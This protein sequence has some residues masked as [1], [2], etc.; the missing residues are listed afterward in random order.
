M[1]RRLSVAISMACVT[2]AAIGCNKSASGE[3]K[4][5]EAKAADAKPADAKPP[6]AAPIPPPSNSDTLQ[7]TDLYHL[8]SVGDVQ[9]SP[10]A[11][12]VAYAGVNS[13]RPGRPYSQIWV[14]NVA[15]RESSRLGAAGETA[16]TP[17]WSPS[18][19]AIAYLGGDGERFG[20]M[21]ANVD[22]ASPRFI[23][24]VESTNHPLP[25]SG[26]QIAWAPDGKQIAF[27]SATPGPEQDANGDPMVVTR[28]LYKPTASEGFTRFN[29]NRRL[30]IF[31][32]DVASGAVRQLTTG[33]YFE[34]SLHWSPSGDRILFVSN[35]ESDPDRF[36]NYDVFTVA[37]S[38]GAIAQ[39]TQTKN[40]EYHPAWSPDG[41]EIAYLGTTRP[42]T[43]SETTME[44][45][46][47]WV[48]NADGSNRHELGRSVDNRQGAPRWSADG[49]VVYFTVQESGDT[50]LYRMPAA[51][52]A[53]ERVLAESG[54]V[55]SWSIATAHGSTMMAY[56]FATPQHPAELYLREGAGAAAQATQLNG[57]LLSHKRIGAVESLTFASFDG[58][59]IQAFLTQPIEHG[60]RAGTPLI[61]MIHGGPHGQQGPEFNSR[62]QLY[63]AR[64][65]ASLMVNYRG[66]TGYG[67]KLT[68]AIFNDQDGG[69]AKDVLAGVDAAL[70]RYPWL[71]GSRMGIEGGSYGGQLANWIITQTDRFKAAI[72]VAGISNLVTQNYLSYYHDYLAV[73]FGG[74][75]HQKGIIDRLWERSAI[76]YAN[77]VKT[78]T[79]FV[80]GEN[81]NDV[82]IA[83]AEQF[84]IALKD[85]GVETIMV[86]YPR[87]GHGIRETRHA[88]D[89]FERSVAWY[90][91]HFGR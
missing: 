28:Y 69:E 23:A 49:R 13:D 63:A 85:V 53:A 42:L 17:R 36:F 82:P 31:V 18:G 80:H 55:G 79:M 9:L 40:A 4:P 59:P 32:A 74:F 89:V 37:V 29:D 73:E 52:G 44:D 57:P 38:D 15:S 22:G 3:A 25:T 2:A 45:T 60:A 90:E 1:L 39:L 14:L 34:H 87:E 48:M 78:P 21:I 47:V 33:N 91:R 71:D 5:A 67:Q 27:V 26:E 12:R 7:V 10:D 75:P 56:A 50:H 86:R 62:A 66:S 8:R 19:Q 84:Y 65:W 30:H 54:S 6:A 58:M 81:D 41:R 35:H 61:V 51:G 72:P 77:R 64:G 68:D 24:P 70:K 20:L 83:E 88:I 76:R 16:S 11:S 43:S 46:H